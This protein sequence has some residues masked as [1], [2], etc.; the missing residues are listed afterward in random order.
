VGRTTLQWTHACSV[1]LQPC[2]SLCA[3]RLALGA[4]EAGFAP[5]CLLY[6]AYFYKPEASCPAARLGSRAPFCFEL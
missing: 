1:P 5:G 3:V 2:R 6:L 4:A